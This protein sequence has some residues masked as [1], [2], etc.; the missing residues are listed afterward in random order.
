MVF[1]VNREGLYSD[2]ERVCNAG[3]KL[4]EKDNFEASDFNKL[5]SMKAMSSFFNAR[6]AILQ[7]ENATDRI[8]LIKQRMKQ[9]GYEES[10]Q[11]T[12]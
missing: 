9:L 10:A 6:I 5:K 8:E 12:G 1:R 2:L 4:L 3:I 7:Q 11:V